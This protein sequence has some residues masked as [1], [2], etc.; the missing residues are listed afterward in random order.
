[1]KTK[2][3]FQSHSL[4]VNFTANFSIVLIKV[5]NDIHVFVNVFIFVLVMNMQIRLKLRGT[6]LRMS[7]RVHSND[8]LFIQI[9]FQDEILKPV[10]TITSLGERKFLHDF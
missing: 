7:N 3:T 9:L 4:T 10:N 1:M 2:N 8:D 5:K 6:C